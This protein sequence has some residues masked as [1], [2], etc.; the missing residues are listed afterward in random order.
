[1]GQ[2]QKQNYFHTSF[3][4]QRITMWS[5]SGMQLCTFNVPLPST[6][7]YAL[8]TDAENEPLVRWPAEILHRYV[9]WRNTAS[10]HGPKLRYCP[11]IFSENSQKGFFIFV[12]LSFTFS[13]DEF[14]TLK[15]LISSYRKFKTSSPTLNSQWPAGLSDCVGVCLCT[16]HLESHI[17]QGAL[18][19]FW[20]PFLT[21]H[22][23]LQSL[24]FP[25]T[26]CT[27]EKIKARQC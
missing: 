12:I 10:H 20:P 21:L 19:V 13:V 17:M 3:Q 14:I 25:D 7:N 27:C 23:L 15:N 1:M 18:Q 24:C 6:A 22:Y 11:A 8:S 4:F 2:V 16:I 5:F 9:E 26:E